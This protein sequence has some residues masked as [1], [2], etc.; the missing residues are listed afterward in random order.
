MATTH[1]VVGA[2]CY[3]IGYRT[4][5]HDE[6]SPENVFARDCAHEQSL[7][8]ELLDHLRNGPYVK[9]APSRVAGVGVVAITDIPAGVDPF[10]PPNASLHAVERSVRLTGDELQSCP[11]AVVAHVLDFHDT[12]HAHTVGG[13]VYPPFIDLNA[14]STVAMDASW[15]LNHSDV[16]NMEDYNPP[17]AASEKPSFASYRT[18]RTVRAGEELFLD[19]KSALPGVYAQ[20]LAQQARRPP[21]H[22]RDPVA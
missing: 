7:K 2:I 20:I 6:Q 22:D 21:Q 11:E 19:Y 14:C 9:L 18:T 3:K 17:A 8:A 10:S 12:K 5:V 13:K 1:A 15:Y 16:A 4:G